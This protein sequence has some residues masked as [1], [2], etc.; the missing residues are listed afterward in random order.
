[1]GAVPGGDIVPL[2]LGCLWL[3]ELG[4]DPVEVAGETRCPVG[5]TGLGLGVD[6]GNLGGFGW[7]GGLA[8]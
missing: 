8:L 5:H 6:L 4:G 7:G 1:M 3:G 2:I